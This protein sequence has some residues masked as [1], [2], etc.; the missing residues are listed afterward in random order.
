MYFNGYGSTSHEFIFATFAIQTFAPTFTIPSFALYLLF[1][2][3]R[4]FIIPFLSM[5]PTFVIIAENV[6]LNCQQN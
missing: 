4:E 3:R 6:Y 2:V 5:V 1:I